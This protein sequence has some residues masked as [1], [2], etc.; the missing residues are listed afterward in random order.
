MMNQPKIERTNRDVSKL[1]GRFVATVCTLGVLVAFAGGCR[2]NQTS[3]GEQ[4][5]GISESSEGG[6]PTSPSSGQSVT[7]GQQAPSSVVGRES[8]SELVMAEFQE[9]RSRLKEVQA[10]LAKIEAK[11]EGNEELEKAR[12]ELETAAIDKM[13]E[14]S[15]GAEEDIEELKKLG[16]EIEERDDA[17]PGS[18]GEPNQSTK[19]DITEFQQKKQE[20]DKLQQEAMQDPE[21]QAF[22]K[23][24]EEAMIAALIKADPKAEALIEEQDK[25]IRRYQ[26]LRKK[27]FQQRMQQQMQ[28][29]LQQKEQRQGQSDEGDSQ[30]LAP[31]AP[32]G[33]GSR[34]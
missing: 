6:M 18:S 22:E 17:G 1:S 34:R 10:Q 9:V 11:V 28:Q 31:V 16:K 3:R 33:S 19:Q 2:S 7:E 21:V 14:S 32:Q 30:Q 13:E 27:I 12:K 25:L 20:I 26:A 23:K 15:P 29:Q 5:P 24:Y 8:N 4:R